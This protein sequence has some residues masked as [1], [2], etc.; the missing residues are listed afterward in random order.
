MSSQATLCEG[1]EMYNAL[2]EKA[3]SEEEKQVRNLMLTN[4]QPCAVLKYVCSDERFQV[5]IQEMYCVH[6]GFML[7]PKYL[8][9]RHG[10]K[11]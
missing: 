7:P 5:L 8:E 10:L 9:M 3:K 2:F 1:I 4:T 6:W 11:S